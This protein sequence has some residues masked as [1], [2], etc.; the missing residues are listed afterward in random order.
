MPTR[1]QLLANPRFQALSPDDQAKVLREHDRQQRNAPPP[2]PAV[3][4]PTAP[5]DRQAWRRELN[6]QQQQELSDYLTYYGR[7]E[8]E[9]GVQD[10]VR[11]RMS[12]GDFVV[13]KQGSVH[14][15]T[16]LA[17]EEEESLWYS[18]PRMGAAAAGRALGVTEYPARVAGE[19][20]E[21]A[22]RA[23][24]VP[25]GAARFVG[26]YGVRG[27]I[28][29]L[30]LMAATWPLGGPIGGILSRTPIVSRAVAPLIEAGEATGAK[31]LLARTGRAA[32]E[33]VGLE[34]ALGATERYAT[35]TPTRAR[36]VMHDIEAGLTWAPAHLGFYEAPRALGRAFRGLRR[37]GERVETEGTPTPEQAAGTVDR[38]PGPADA[39]EQ[40]T[41][42][43]VLDNVAATTRD[44]PQTKG[45]APLGEGEIRE[46]GTFFGRATPEEQ[47]QYELAREGGRP[48]GY[49]VGGGDLELSPE[50]RAARVLAG[51]PE[52]PPEGFMGEVP[53]PPIPGGAFV[54]PRQQPTGE[55]L[56]LP[57]EGRMVTRVAP[58]A[59]METVDYP[60]VAGT[61]RGG[62]PEQTWMDARREALARAEQ[63]SRALVPQGER[64]LTT[65]PPSLASVTSEFPM[66]PR[67]MAAEA[68][69]ARAL[70]GQ[71]TAPEVVQLGQGFDRDVTAGGRN[72]LD[73][74][75]RQLREDALIRDRA[76]RA[77][78]PGM[79]VTGG[80]M[81]TTPPAPAPHPES[82]PGAAP[83]IG[84][85]GEV[86]FPSGFPP[87]P[88]APGF[89]GPETP[90]GRMYPGAGAPPAP[91]GRMY[92]GPGGPA[93]PL[94]P[95]PFGPVEPGEPVPP[96]P[97]GGPSGGAP[98]GPPRPGGPPP[99]PPAGPTGDLASPARA[100][101]LGD[102]AIWNKLV[103]DA[104]DETLW[105][106]LLERG[107]TDQEFVAAIEEASGE[108]PAKEVLTRLKRVLLLDDPRPTSY[109][110]AELTYAIL[111]KDDQ[112][113]ADTR[114]SNHAEVMQLQGIDPDN[115]ESTG[116]MFAGDYK[117]GN[118]VWKGN[119]VVDIQ[120]AAEGAAPREAT[121][122][123]KVQA[124]ARELQ[125]L[126]GKEP[127]VIE[128]RPA[129]A[130][131]G[132]DARVRDI[133]GAEPTQANV[134]KTLDELRERYDKEAFTLSDDAFEK[135]GR[136]IADLD[137]YQQELERPKEA[138]AERSLI[139][140]EEPKRRTEEE[141]P[142]DDEDYPPVVESKEI[143][144][145]LAQWKREN[146]SPEERNKRALGVMRPLID[147]TIERYG[148][149][150]A[151]EA[152]EKAQQLMGERDQAEAR[153]E[154]T[155]AAKLDNQI[156]GLIQYR[157][158]A[159]QIPA[160][161][162]TWTQRR[163]AV[164]ADAE[165]RGLV[166]GAKV[167][168]T[169]NG[170]QYTGTLRGPG[171]TPEWAWVD[172][173]DEYGRPGGDMGIP[174]ADLQLVE[175]GRKQPK[176][177]ASFAR[178]F[179]GEKPEGLDVGSRVRI[180]VEGRKG[181]KPRQVEATIETVDDKTGT[182]TF[183]D[184]RGQ[185]Y[186]W[187]WNKLEVLTEAHLEGRKPPPSELKFAPEDHPVSRE[188]LREKGYVAAAKST[189]LHK[190]GYNVVIWRTSQ[191]SPSNAH[192]VYEYVPREKGSTLPRRTANAD[193]TATIQEIERSVGVER[194][195]GEL[196][197]R[198]PK[199]P[200]PGMN[201]RQRELVEER[202]AREWGENWSAQDLLEEVIRLRQHKK[203][204]V[205][206]DRRNVQHLIDRTADYIEEVREG[207]AVPPAAAK[208]D[209]AAAEER[210]VREAGMKAS[211]RT[212]EEVEEINRG[213]LG[214]E[215]GRKPGEELERI[216]QERR[217]G[218]A[219]RLEAAQDYLREHRDADIQTAWNASAKTLDLPYSAHK[220]GLD[221]LEE[222]A[223]DIAK[224][225]R[226]KAKPG[227]GERRV[228]AIDRA[229]V[230]PKREEVVQLAIERTRKAY[231][232]YV[233]EPSKVE[234]AAFTDTFTKTKHVKVGETE[235][236]K[237][238]D[239]MTWEG[240][241]D[242]DGWTLETL[243]RVKIDP[244]Y[245]SFL[246]P[247][248]QRMPGLTKGQSAAEFD[249]AKPENWFVDVRVRKM[250]EGI[251]P[252]GAR[253]KLETLIQGIDPR[254]VLVRLPGE[255]LVASRER[256]G[257]AVASTASR[258]TTE[259]KPSTPT[260]DEILAQN[261]GAKKSG[262]L[263]DSTT[264]SADVP[265][266]TAE[267]QAGYVANALDRTSEARRRAEEAGEDSEVRR[268]EAAHDGIA[269]GFH[270]GTKTYREQLEKHGFKESPGIPED[271]PR[272]WSSVA[273][274]YLQSAQDRFA[275]HPVL[276]RVVD[277]AKYA[278]DSG[279]QLRRAFVTRAAA[280]DARGQP[281]PGTGGWDAVWA[282]VERDRDKT[283]YH[284]LEQAIIQSELDDIYHTREELTSKGLNPDTIAAYRGLHRL[285]RDGLERVINPLRKRLG[286]P[287]ISGIKGFYFPHKWLGVYEIL[288]KTGERVETPNGQASFATLQ[289]ARKA[290][291]AFKHDNPSAE[292]EIRFRREDVVDEVTEAGES[293]AIRKLFEAVDA[294][295]AELRERL[296]QGLAA[297]R[298]ARG[299][300]RHLEHRVGATGYEKGKLAQIGRD[301]FNQL[302][303]YAPRKLATERIV[304]ILREFDETRDPQLKE[305]L[306]AFLNAFHGKQGRVEREFDKAILRSP[307]GAFL[308][309]R[310][311]TRELTSGG[312]ELTAHAKIGMFNP[313][314]FVMNL[315]QPISHTLP[316]VGGRSF[317]EG[318][319]G[320]L[321]PTKEQQLILQLA[322]KKGLLDPRFTEAPIP[323]GHGQ[324]R[325]AMDQV[326]KV[327][328]Y[329]GQLS[330]HWNRALTLLAA[331]DRLQREGPRDR[332][333]RFAY[334]NARAPRVQVG[335]EWQ[336]FD[337]KN[338]QHM[339]DFLRRV[340]DR[341]QFRY[342]VT[343]RARFMRSALG[344][345]WGQFRSYVTN[346]MGMQRRYWQLAKAGEV[347]PLALHLGAGLALAGLATIPGRDAMDTLIEW[348]SGH[349][350]VDL[351]NKQV[352]KAQAKGGALGTAA[353]IA[354][355]GLPALVGV[356][357]TRR[358]GQADFIPS[359][360]RDFAP[361]VMNMAYGL[362]DD[363]LNNGFKDAMRGA[364]PMARWMEQVRQHATGTVKD[365]Y[366]R[367]LYT[368][369]AWTDMK[370]LPSATKLAQ[371]A[372]IAAGLPTTRQTQTYEQKISAQKEHARQ[373]KQKRTLFQAILD[374]QDSKD[375]A[376][377]TAAVKAA[378][379]AGFEVTTKT[380]DKFRKSRE[381][382]ASTR[383]MRETP[384]VLRPE[385]KSWMPPDEANRA[386]RA[387][388]GGR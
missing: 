234:S 249:F 25:G 122:E 102:D 158:I 327:S 16:H 160:D 323:A 213:L 91:S 371:M 374:A 90:T 367:V 354:K 316:I 357:V 4:G 331:Y 105:R 356:D 174:Y 208:A 251:D 135:M 165:K 64:A 2:P 279:T 219:Q 12:T 175:K 137:E 232:D 365:R 289:E 214:T 322:L 273:G 229:M 113:W 226:I 209:K 134:E 274:S 112:V 363:Y 285:F 255:S 332:I 348:I 177:K 306:D 330:E 364:L 11:D 241:G 166:E 77:G 34:P 333:V 304:Q 1:D 196:I 378:R 185:A 211:F 63:A 66:T 72:T 221:A 282:A 142:R 261:P 128:E 3:A 86:V 93:R 220:G 123:E 388:Q 53:P 132:L 114:A 203:E 314:F 9:H 377:I 101:E 276:R 186:H 284:K 124:Q 362:F 296:E 13:D 301:Y 149:L 205:P 71:P 95:S 290:A 118:P 294:K 252:E 295:D 44:P 222:A 8:Q 49:P 206:G 387:L 107:V 154:G 216:D 76:K 200:Q 82:G 210:R 215:P 237:G 381:T 264:P 89:V 275:N 195:P 188:Q 92:P 382:P 140:E 17:P 27:P 153:G 26:Q 343:D 217:E 52:P 10:F 345:T 187:P 96:G 240:A 139:P 239:K 171:T 85:R 321:K 20:T 201:P 80:A 368:E 257:E 358:I 359:R 318:V 246:M 150:T 120:P 198:A 265:E 380:V 243:P 99:R 87:A 94:E 169:R 189:D 218:I 180:S 248:G 369:P 353:S 342:D 309:P 361:P 193:D 98:P 35:A 202:M 235:G 228:W 329:L 68:R 163:E 244:S 338:R 60:T 236:R 67:R 148:K 167:T 326:K 194:K 61:A 366:G 117:A 360:W 40:A 178:Q 355:G 351:F 144:R 258:T 207:R 43:A 127:D 141:E 383:L 328:F 56:T 157:S 173:R 57:G 30:P 58:G 23:L 147:W 81:P 299:F 28:A 121:T 190:H 325:H 319:S 224:R 384:K 262:R 303:G 38:A 24:G 268:E 298:T 212:K 227:T 181:T 280:K 302:S 136:D 340:V 78:G 259:A 155:L 42:N 145:Y 300:I 83:V 168:F 315:T 260:P 335:N 184:E 54:G 46:P 79:E 233:T 281:K 247:S 230:W 151:K 291:R 146:L 7:D 45:L 176:V 288:L 14:E 106:D 250:P 204:V 337:P 272:R 21:S 385:V 293:A 350:L 324:Y 223:R 41:A 352:W 125:R 256:L 36:D 22:L 347:S 130:E 100:A 39:P 32:L 307:I 370:E 344:L 138:P 231:G 308:D 143:D 116:F 270:E 133:V 109:A 172:Y 75:Q 286:L 55:F 51:R 182:V 97:E 263:Y 159:D 267:K 65:M 31:A 152:R 297:T 197:P 103:P 126:E 376:A 266:G 59:D 50:Q 271:T 108:R 192:L 311:A 310:R 305:D 18:L 119:R 336:A 129:E 84:P 111:D 5:P 386:L 242:W 37:P 179:N 379:D 199:T 115:V 245:R 373:V 372:G 73:D 191:G 269:G 88:Q 170:K 238:G 339:L 162:K 69:A 29:S 161:Y 156:S 312:R 33:G 104:D 110:P 164:L 283:Q 292:P 70:A 15:A 320:L 131:K 341:T 225:A 19:K 278:L 334:D 62:R 287:A 74:L 313:A 48:G 253:E 47:L 6:P 346:T 183:H 277:V 375:Q 349:S 317:G 254:T